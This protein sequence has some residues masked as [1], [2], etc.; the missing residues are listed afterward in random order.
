MQGFFIEAE[1]KAQPRALGEEYFREVVTVDLAT[2]H[3]SKAT[4]ADLA[5]FQSPAKPQNR[6]S[7]DARKSTHEG[8]D[9]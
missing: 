6:R 2:G 9:G 3:S 4:D 7:P 8:A 1:S 5:I